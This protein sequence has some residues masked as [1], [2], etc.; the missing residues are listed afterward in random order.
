MGNGCEFGACGNI[1][2]SFT[3]G[4]TTAPLT[5]CATHPQICAIP[6]EAEGFFSRVVPM[7]TVGS[8]TMHM[9]GDKA[10]PRYCQQVQQ[11]AITTCAAKYV[12]KG[13]GSDAPLLVRKCVRE[14]MESAGCS[15]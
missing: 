9:T 11:K 7:L 5:W 13:H 2:D 15:Y 10:D 6:A 3:T 8:I 14:I 4:V 12:G 1:G